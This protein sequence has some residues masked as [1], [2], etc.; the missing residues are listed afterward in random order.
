MFRKNE[1]IEVVGEDK[2]RELGRDT[3]KQR[4]REI[5]TEGDTLGKRIREHFPGRAS[6]GVTQDR[7][8]V[9]HQ[10]SWN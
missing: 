2:E 5:K 1:P 3:E 9:Q 4:Q 10:D 8:L 7:N 6:N